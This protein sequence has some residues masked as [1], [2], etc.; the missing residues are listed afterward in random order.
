[1]VKHKVAGYGFSDWLAQRITAVVLGTYFFYFLVRV[2]TI[3][4]NAAILWQ[5]FFNP[6]TQFFTMIA[7]VAL[8]WHAWIGVR[9][10]WM[11]YVKSTALRLFLHALTATALIGYLAWAAKVLFQING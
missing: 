2:I 1:M 9:D 6:F 8:C 5:Q 4:P 11:D 7:F 10:I 3:K